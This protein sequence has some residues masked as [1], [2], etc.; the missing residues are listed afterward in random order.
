MR[1]TNAA[2]I[3]VCLVLIFGL[4]LYVSPLA[5]PSIP[6]VRGTTHT[7]SLVGNNPN[8]NTSNPNPIITVTKGD[9]VTINLSSGDAAT[10]QLLIDFDGDYAGGTDCTAMAD[11]CSSTFSPSTPTRLGP[12]TI[13][14]NAGQYKYYCTV[15]YPYMQGLFI[16]EN[17]QFRGNDH[18][19]SFSISSR[20][21]DQF[22][23]QHSCG[24]LWN[25][26][27]FKAHDLNSPINFTWVLR[28]H[29]N[30][31]KWVI[32]RNSYHKHKRLC[33]I[34]LVTEFHDQL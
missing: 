5:L 30:W 12:F 34:T 26:S 33:C 6:P 16:V 10:H 11:W 7:I 9:T 14:S 4:T 23:H 19:L 28:H 21:N 15:H 29:R 18:S 25:N 31:N 13:T 27:Q 22:Q 20:T 1:F 3:L 17:Q 24:L 2:G 32:I 8:W